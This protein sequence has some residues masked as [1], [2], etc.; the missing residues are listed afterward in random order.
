MLLQDEGSIDPKL[1]QALLMVAPVADPPPL[2]EEVSP[3]Y[4]IY[5]L[6]LFSYAL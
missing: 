1:M 2:S 6:N 5:V 3:Y 4:I